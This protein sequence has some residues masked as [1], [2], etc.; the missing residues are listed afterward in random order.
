MA[1]YFLLYA[2]MYP[3]QQTNNTNTT[4]QTIQYFTEASVSGEVNIKSY[5]RKMLDL[6]LEVAANYL[7][8]K[9]ITN[10]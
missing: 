7:R 8:S 1:E 3:K 10:F 5:D 6:L 9:N 4:T 2:M